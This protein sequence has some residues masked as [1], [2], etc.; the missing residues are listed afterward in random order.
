MNLAIMVDIA[1]ILLELFTN[2]KYMPYLS[3]Y[4][5]IF[6]T[7]LLFSYFHRVRLNLL[8]M[9]EEYFVWGIYQDLFRGW[10]III[11]SVNC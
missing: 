1:K 5:N 6:S 9:G 10:Y 7:T 3:L 8:A 4:E 11:G 2:Y